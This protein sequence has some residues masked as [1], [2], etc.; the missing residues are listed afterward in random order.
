MLTSSP[1]GT[2][3]ILPEEARR[4]QWME[5]VARS[6]CARY[7]YEEIRTP[8]FEHTEL[9]ERGVGDA[10][11]IVE[12]EMYTFLDRSQRSLTLRPEGTAGVVRAYLQARLYSQPQPIKLYYIGPMFRYGRPQSGRLRQFHQFGVEAFGSEAADLDAEV[13]TLAGDFF[14]SLGL[15]GLELHLNSVGCADCR[16]GYRQEL[17][18]YLTPRVGELCETCR[19]RYE[20]N[21][22]RILDCKNEAC[23]SLSVGAPKVTS[24]LCP[25]CA[26]HLRA[27]ENHLRA[28]GMAYVLDPFLVRG[29]DYYTST[30]FEI[31][32]PGEAGGSIGG[33][34][35][36]D[37]LVEVCGGPPTPAVGFAVGLERTL[38]AMKQQ[39]LTPA[40]S[41]GPLVFVAVAAPEAR[42]AAWEVLCALRRAGLNAD[43]DFLSR[44]LKAQMKYAD[45]LGA[46][47]AVILGPEEIAGG[48]VTVRD[49]QHGIQDR[50]N[51]DELIGYLQQFLPD[52][53]VENK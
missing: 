42:A 45:R 50:V 5:A 48:W 12:K 18:Q 36:Y 32:L 46:R 44:S 11:D 39:G 30:A 28:S 20:R 19:S 16:P 41:R 29:L 37:K 14:Q 27:V 8:A 9:F 26:A 49:L 40:P 1:R 3:D 33:G 43:K 53:Q 24:F 21:P 6:L 52:K 13:I 25:K 7:G 2:T 34:G 10:T 47:L 51:R 4:W 15:T 22:L 31:M 23:Q 35:R 17:V 38:L